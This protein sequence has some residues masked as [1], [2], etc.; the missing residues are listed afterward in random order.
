MM[1]TV[2]ALMLMQIN[3]GITSQTKF[4]WIIKLVLPHLKFLERSRFNRRCRQL[5][6][7]INRIR[8]GLTAQSEYSDLAIID[9]FPIPVCQNVRNQRARIFKPIADIGYNATKRMWFYGFKIHVVMEAD[10]LILNYVVT[11]AS[12]HDSR[13]AVELIQ[14][15]P[16]HEVIAD[17]GYVGHNLVE[18]FQRDGYQLWTPYRSNMK[19]AK[20][21]NSRQLK[22]IRRRIESCFSCLDQSKVEHNT[23]R[24]CSGFQTIL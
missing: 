10:G 6:P 24:T 5:L 23:S 16:C 19:G 8:R 12:V 9:S 20:E 22:K 11:K 13:E 18:A 7:T 21:H 14:G 4:C 17:V 1:P 15:C 3:G 2:L